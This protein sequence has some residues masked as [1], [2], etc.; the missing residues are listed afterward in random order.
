MGRHQLPATAVD[1]NST[2]NTQTRWWMPTAPPDTVGSRYNEITT[3]T[4]PV[5]DATSNTSN[6]AVAVSAHQGTTRKATMVGDNQ[7]PPAQPW[8]WSNPISMTIKRRHP[9]RGPKTSRRLERHPRRGPK[10]R[11]V[12]L[13]EERI[14][15]DGPWPQPLVACSSKEAAVYAGQ[16]KVWRKAVPKLP[17]A[18]SSTRQEK[19]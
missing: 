18:I 3:K 11:K 7:S 4:Q 17:P 15:S 5:V 13:E 14:T 16:A 9:R 12:S 10:K 1:A 2:T 19:R 6:T 8:Q